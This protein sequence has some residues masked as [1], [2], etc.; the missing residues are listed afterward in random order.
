MLDL[1]FYK[2]DFGNLR[3]R[4][5]RRVYSNCTHINGNLFLV[6]LRDRDL[7]RHSFKYLEVG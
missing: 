2:G 4:D 3:Q 6:D 5:M 1:P 7:I